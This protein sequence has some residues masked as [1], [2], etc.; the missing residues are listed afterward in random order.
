MT[1]AHLVAC[2]SCARHV[3]V[4]EATCPFCATGLPEAARSTQPRRAP[5]ERLSRAALYAFGV[6][7]LAVAAACS[8]TSTTKTPDDGGSLDAETHDTGADRQINVPY[9]QPAYGASPFDAGEAVEAGEGDAGAS[10][11]AGGNLND[12]GEPTDAQPDHF[13]GGALYGGPGV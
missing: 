12:S 8:S 5:T 10:G 1:S 11:D 13:M 9:G 6:G 3:R 4:S 7:G 2:P